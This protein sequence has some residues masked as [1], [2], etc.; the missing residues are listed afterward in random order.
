MG[1]ATW[2]RRGPLTLR[3]LRDAGCKAAEVCAVRRC[4]AEELHA[5]GFAETVS[6]NRVEGELED[7]G[8]VYA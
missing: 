5:A 2:S 1:V 8:M 4:T 3:E 6:A 7:G